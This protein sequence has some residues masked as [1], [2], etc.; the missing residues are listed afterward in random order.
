MAGLNKRATVA[1]FSELTG[2]IAWLAVVYA[3][4]AADDALQDGIDAFNR[5]DLIA[6]MASFE[7]AADAGSA[8][9]QARLAWILDQAEENAKAVEL[10]AAS[11]EQGHANGQF[12]LAEMYAKGEGVEA[13]QQMALELYLRAADQGHLRAMRKLAIAYRHGD[14]GLIADEAEASLWEHRIARAEQ[15]A[16]VE[17]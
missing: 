7:E 8:E 3:S 12:G 6:A 2:L 17:N 4:S 14:L 1:T 10:Y 13:D 15:G 9:A 11:A 5:G 16:A